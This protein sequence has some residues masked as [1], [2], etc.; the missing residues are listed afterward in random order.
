VCFGREVLKADDGFSSGYLLSSND[1]YS[2][3]MDQ[4]MD[5][6]HIFSWSREVVSH[7]FLQVTSMGLAVY[8]RELK[9]ILP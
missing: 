9:V 4:G 1:I 7:I 2:V 5:V 8:T 3:L 6:F